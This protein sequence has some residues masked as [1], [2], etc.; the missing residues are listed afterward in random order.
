MSPQGVRGGYPHNSVR[1][2]CKHVG[3]FKCR[4]QHSGWILCREE[5]GYDLSEQQQDFL[6]L[7]PRLSW[8]NSWPAH[9]PPITRAAEPPPLSTNSSHTTYSWLLKQIF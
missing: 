2:I 5:R 3:V 6:S 1:F 7:P 9:S 8:A 4:K